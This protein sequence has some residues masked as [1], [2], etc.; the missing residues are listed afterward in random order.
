MNNISSVVTLGS[1]FSKEL[2]QTIE[3]SY[4]F[5]RYISNEWIFILYSE[6][7]VYLFKEYLKRNKS[8]FKG[9]EIKY[10][11]C[12]EGISKSM[13]KGIVITQNYWILILHSGDYL[14]EDLT[15]FKLTR[16]TLHIQK[17]NDILIF[18]S[19]YKNK[20]S[21]IGKSNHFNTKFRPPYELS[22][23]HQSTF[24]SRKVYEEFKYS[25][26]FKSSM[27]YEFF[28]RCKLKN[29]KFKSFLFYTTVYTLGGTSSNVFLSAKEMKLAIRKNIKNRYLKFYLVNI[30]LNFIVLRKLLFKYLYFTNLTKIRKYFIK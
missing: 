2:Y 17:C 25:K 11:F 27:D 19:I 6:E 10:D 16:E 21:Y 12:S 24:I 20:N 13:N 7:E 22:I 23:P 3:N 9:I 29:F 26:D 14:I 18:G 8:I 15:I 4:K 28:L 5:I 30:N 1:Y